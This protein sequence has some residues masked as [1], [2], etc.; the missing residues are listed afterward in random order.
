[1]IQISS[2]F[3]RLSFGLCGR[4]TAAELLAFFLSFG[5][6][7]LWV[8]TGHWLLMDGKITCRRYILEK[9]I[10]PLLALG[11]GLC[12]AFIALVRLPSLKVSTLLLSGLLI[13]DVAW[14]NFI[15]IVNV[16]F[17]IRNIFQMFTFQVFFSSYLFNTNVMVKVATRPAENPVRLQ[18]FHT[19]LVLFTLFCLRF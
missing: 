11:M 8:L 18:N 14:V 9:I 1:M 19:F 4:Y 10:F 16:S 17:F 3:C 2:L 12:V 13:Y 5:L 7:C 6:V 15:A